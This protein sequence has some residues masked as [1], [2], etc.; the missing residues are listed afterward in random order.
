LRAHQV[1]EK[2]HSGIL[3]I[4]L[5][6]ENERNLDDIPE[7]V[8]GELKF[9]CVENLDEVIKTALRNHSRT[10]RKNGIKKLNI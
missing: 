5:P 10:S 1:P 8:K 2:H 7:E 6:K 9:I 3:K 4:I